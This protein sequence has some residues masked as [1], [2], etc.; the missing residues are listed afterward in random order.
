M[1]DT[2]SRKK[3]KFICLQYVEGDGGR[4]EPQVTDQYMKVHF[5]HLY[6]ERLA[7]LWNESLARL[8]E[9]E[10]SAVE[11]FRIMLDMTE[12][13]LAARTGLGRRRV[14]RHGTPAGFRRASVEELLKYADVFGVPLAAFFVVLGE[15]SAGLALEPLPATGNVLCRL[16]GEEKE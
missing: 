10:I 3:G 15:R 8:L 2:D 14:R 13:E 4:L 1:T 16:K 6:D 7:K 5:G 9:G 11:L 12:I